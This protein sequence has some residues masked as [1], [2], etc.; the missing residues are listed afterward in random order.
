MKLPNKGQRRRWRIE[1]EMKLEAAESERLEEEQRVL[2]S[3]AAALAARIQ[4]RFNELLHEIP[5]LIARAID[6][7]K[8]SISVPFR[9]TGTRLWTPEDQLVGN[10]LLRAYEKEPGYSISLQ[11]IDCG[12]NAADLSLGVNS[13]WVSKPL[14]GVH[15]EWEEE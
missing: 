11:D 2:D 5:N 7:G 10:E 9:N 8:N 4:Q 12:Y 1:R 15:I 6:E 13:R 14:P 3:Q